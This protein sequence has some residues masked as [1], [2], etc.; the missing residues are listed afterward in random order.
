[1]PEPRRRL[2]R[3]HRARLP[4]NKHALRTVGPP[5][6]RSRQRNRHRQTLQVHCRAATT[7]RLL[8]GRQMGRS[9]HPILLLR[10]LHSSS[11]Q[12][13]GARLIAQGSR[14]RLVLSE[15]RWLVRRHPRSR[16]TRSLCF[17][18]CGLAE[19]CGVFGVV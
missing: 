7:Q 8:L 11:A 4:H 15:L 5:Y 2:R 13:T 14:V 17:L 1:M 16:I 9:R 19:D 10:A 6:V 3:E 18:L 12:P